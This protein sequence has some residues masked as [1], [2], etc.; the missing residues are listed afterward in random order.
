SGACDDNA[1]DHCTGSGNAC[2]DVFQ[3]AG[4]TCRD[5]AGQCDVAETCSGTSGAC[6]ADG[7]ASSSTHCLG[8]SQGGGCDD[9]AADHCTGTGNACVDVFQAAGYTCRDSAGQCDVAETCP[10]TSG[11][12]PVDGFASS[13][14][15]CLGASQ[16]GGCDN[17]AADHCTGSGNACVD[18][19]QAAGYTCRGSA[20]QF[21]LAETCPGTSGACPADGFAA[22]S[23]HCLT[24]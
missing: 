3:A 19:F 5:S 23:T 13:S 16:G 14:T 17:D 9:D 10:G 7:F 24:T 11:A 6:P 21:D 20:G 15:H 4:Y 1:A 12:C 18:V 22:S 2:V 8:T